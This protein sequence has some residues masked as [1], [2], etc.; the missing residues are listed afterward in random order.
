MAKRGADKMTKKH[1]YFFAVKLPKEVKGFLNKWVEQHRTDFPFDRWVHPEDYHITLAFLGFAEKNQLTDATN[2]IRERLN[3]V[4]QFYL[5][6]NKTGTFG[7]PKS[8]R[9]FWADV[10][11]SEELANIQKSVY[12]QCIALGFELDKK[13]FRP[14]ITLAR[15]WKGEQPFDVNSLTEVKTDNGEMISFLVSDIVLYESHVEETPK[16]KEIETIQ[17][18]ANVQS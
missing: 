18:K 13:P 12:E 6:L 4:N 14:H 2:K 7:S 10:L 15:K 9:I 16:Y 5:T 11:P 8:P 1:H 17:L 3:E